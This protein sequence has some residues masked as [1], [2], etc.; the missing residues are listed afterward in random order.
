MKADKQ[1]VLLSMHCSIEIYRDGSYVGEGYFIKRA[2]VDPYG[3]KQSRIINE[4]GKIEFIPTSQIVAIG[5]VV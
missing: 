4:S 1:K 5:G 2:G 3:Q